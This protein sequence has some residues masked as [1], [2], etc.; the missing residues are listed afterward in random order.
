MEGPA[1]G[2]EEKGFEGGDHTDEAGGDGHGA[3][4]DGDGLDEHWLWV[5]LG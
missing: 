3:H 1:L 4:G 2:G 5:S